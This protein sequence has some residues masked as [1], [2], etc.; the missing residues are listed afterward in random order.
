[1]G[2]KAGKGAVPAGC[3]QTEVG[4]IPEEWG[5]VRLE[6]ITTL[7]TNGFVGI[8]TIHYTESDDGVLYIQGYNV[9]ENGFEFHG[10]KYVTPSFHQEHMRSCLREGDLLTIQTGEIGLT[11]VVPKNLS[12]SNCHALIISRLNQNRMNPQYVSFYINS[13][14][15]KNRLRL[16]ETGTT[17]KH[18]NVGDVVDYLVPVPP[19]PEQRAIAA[20]LS[21]ADALIDA[22]GRLVT[23]KR[24]IKEGAMQELLTGRRRLPGFEKKKGHKQTEVG[25][26]PED[27]EVVT[28]GSISDIGRGRVISHL[29]IEKSVNPK[30]PVYSSQTSNYGI[31][32]YID[33]YD[34]EGEYITWTTDGVNAGTVFYRC[35]RF[36]CTNVCG[37]VKL[38]SH[39]HQ[40]IALVLNRHTDQYVSR[41][42]GNPKLM[43]DIMKKIVIPITPDKSEQ[44]A[45]AAVLSD[46]DAELESLEAKLAKARLVKRGMMQ[47]LLTG[48]VRL[49]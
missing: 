17:M 21:D 43:N 12:G 8:A 11:T 40:F 26:I 16:F 38:K 36:N 23:K 9:K 3:K 6:D 19:L 46:I 47:E 20:A 29:E 30:Y 15:G 4:V 5:V 18:L 22:L 2:V 27:W 49:V 28:I 1:M 14:P 48:R 32:G 41:H 37:T 7:M 24:R 33:G 25:V 35:G 31:M 39:N 44:S 45:I 13:I 10:I 34:F 42:L